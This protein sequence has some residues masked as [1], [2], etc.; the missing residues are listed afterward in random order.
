MLDNEGFSLTEVSAYA[1]HASVQTTM[2][3]VGE[4]SENVVKKM[5]QN[6]DKECQNSKE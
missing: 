6:F 5:Q 4:S 3:Y 2:L 1:R